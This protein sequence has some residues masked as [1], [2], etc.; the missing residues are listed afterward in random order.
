MGRISTMHN[1]VSWAVISIWFSQLRS[2][3]SVKFSEIELQALNS[4]LHAN[5]ELLLDSK[6]DTNL[7]DFLTFL[8][9]H[10]LPSIPSFKVL[11]IEIE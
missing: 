1:S 7:V 11:R 2:L 9:S 8:T 10:F 5:F 3:Q 4:I 6:Y